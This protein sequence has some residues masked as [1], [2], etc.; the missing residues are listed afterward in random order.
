MEAAAWNLEIRALFWD[1][2]AVVSGPLYIFNFKQYIMYC[3][4]IYLLSC[5]SNL[6]INRRLRGFVRERF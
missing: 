2:K 6:L 4:F 5:Q 3:L 1:F